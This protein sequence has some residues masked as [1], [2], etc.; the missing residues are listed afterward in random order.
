MIEKLFQVIDKLNVELNLNID[1][2]DNSVS[3]TDISPK[4]ATQIK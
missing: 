2:R 3:A 4:T 1:L